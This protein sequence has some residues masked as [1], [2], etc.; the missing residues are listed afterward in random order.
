MVLT[1]LG[2]YIIAL[3]PVSW[4]PWPHRIHML[5]VIIAGSSMLATVVLDWLLTKPRAGRYTYNWRFLRFTSLTC[6]IAGGWL[7]FGSA[8]LIGWYSVALLGEML[9]LGGYLQWIV[10]KTYMGEGNRTALAKI[11]HKIVLVD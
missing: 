6:I 7:T 9:L 3:M 11:L 5:G 2:L 1:V 10:L 8:D 4:N